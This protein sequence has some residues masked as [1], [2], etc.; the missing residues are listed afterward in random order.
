LANLYKIPLWVEIIRCVEEK[1]KLNPDK[2]GKNGSFGQAYGLVNFCFAAGVMVGPIWAGFVYQ[3]AG[4]GT[5]AWSLGLV[6]ALSAIPT[7]LFTGGNIFQRKN[8]QDPEDKAMTGDDRKVT[9]ET[10]T[11]SLKAASSAVK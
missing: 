9:K 4:W 11:P 1:M 8:D 6:S 3:Q 5:M 2:F 10:S 7:A